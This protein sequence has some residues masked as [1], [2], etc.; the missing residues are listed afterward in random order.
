VEGPNNNVK[1]NLASFET[2]GEFI[3]VQEHINQIP[4]AAKIQS[5]CKKKGAPV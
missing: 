1:N 5:L 4:G 2:V 3:M